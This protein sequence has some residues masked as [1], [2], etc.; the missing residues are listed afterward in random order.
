M[1]ILLVEQ[2]GNTHDNP[3]QRTKTV[4]LESDPGG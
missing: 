2:E 1:G 4:V 3:L